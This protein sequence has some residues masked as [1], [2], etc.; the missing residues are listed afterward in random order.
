MWYILKQQKDT[1]KKKKKQQK[2]WRI[3][4][5]GERKRGLWVNQWDKKICAL[6]ADKARHLYGK[7][8]H[9]SRNI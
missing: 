1:F 4:I 3:G 9:N 7:R 2:D 8:N 5:L 6:V